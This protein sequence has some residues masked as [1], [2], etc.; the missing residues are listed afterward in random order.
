MAG[1]YMAQLIAV[2]IC[3]TKLKV[4]FLGGEPIRNRSGDSALK[5]V[6]DIFKAVHA[7]EGEA[8]VVAKFKELG[9]ALSSYLPSDYRDAEGCV[10]DQLDRRGLSYL[11]NV[12]AASAAVLRVCW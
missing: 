12:G 10:S 11:N 6:L 4:A 1:T 8:G 7:T 2:G 9:V 5:L 3:T